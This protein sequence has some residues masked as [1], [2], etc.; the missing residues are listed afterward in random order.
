MAMNVPLTTHCIFHDGALPR[1]PSTAKTMNALIALSLSAPPMPCVV[2]AEQRRGG[3][4]PFAFQE[5]LWALSGAL[6]SGQNSRKCKVRHGAFSQ[7]VLSLFGALRVV[8]NG[9]VCGCDVSLSRRWSLYF[10]V[11]HWLLLIGYYNL[12]G[13]SLFI[14]DQPVIIIFKADPFGCNPRPRGHHETSLCSVHSNSLSDELTN[15]TLGHGVRAA[16]QSLFLLIFN[17]F[18]AVFRF[19]SVLLFSSFVFPS[20]V[21]F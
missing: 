14:L 2:V 18:R 20:P 13:V 5:M 16:K 8:C 7:L 19:E 1:R 10:F 15:H 11:A 4:A 12:C 21:I 17:C 9:S 6:W 3:L